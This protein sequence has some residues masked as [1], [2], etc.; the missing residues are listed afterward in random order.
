MAIFPGCLE[1]TLSSHSSH[2]TRRNGLSF[3]LFGLCSYFLDPWKSWTIDY[4]KRTNPRRS[5]LPSRAWVKVE[6][7]EARGMKDFDAQVRS[8][9]SSLIKSK[10]VLTVCM[11]MFP[12]TWAWRMMATTVGT[13]SA[14][15]NNII[16]NNEFAGDQTRPTDLANEIDHQKSNRL[17]LLIMI[18]YNLPWPRLI[19]MNSSIC[20]Q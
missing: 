7:V 4:P 14:V 10:N 19:P 15:L 3:E 17:C 5:L 2:G 1:R 11:M 20:L 13:I 9:A 6:F 16:N 18:L 8:S 12:R